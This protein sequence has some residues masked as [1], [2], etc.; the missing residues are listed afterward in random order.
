MTNK[1]VAK[2]YA[3]AKKGHYLVLGVYNDRA[4]AEACIK[5]REDRYEVRE[6]IG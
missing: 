6:V 5:G 1:R 3:V 4:K 2:R